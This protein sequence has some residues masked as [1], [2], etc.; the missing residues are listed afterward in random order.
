M[1]PGRLLN[2]GPGGYKLPAF[3][4]APRQFNV[5]LL[6]GADNKVATHYSTVIILYY[7]PTALRYY[8]TAL[9]R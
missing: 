4:D 7:S 6:S 2:A 5:R 9:L 1:K 3:N 8:S